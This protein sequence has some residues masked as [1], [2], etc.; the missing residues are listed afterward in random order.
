MTNFST[1]TILPTVRNREA[2]YNLFVLTI[3][4]TTA[5]NMQI[6]STFLLAVNAVT[7][8]AILAQK[9]LVSTSAIKDIPR[10]GFG[11]WN[12]KSDHHNASNAVEHAIKTGYRHIDCAAIYGNEPDVGRGIKKGLEAAGLKREEIWVTSKLWNDHHDALQVQAG[13]AKT[14]E[15]LGVGYLDL[16]LMHWPVASKDGKNSIKFVETWKA[17]ELLVNAGLVRHI[18]ISNFDPAQLEELLAEAYIRPYAHQMELHPYLPQSAWLQYHYEQGI[19][20]TAYS[21]LGNSNPTYHESLSSD[22]VRDMEKSKSTV[23]ALLEHP[24]VKDVAE[25]RNCTP[26]TVALKW[27][28][29]RGS[30]VIPKSQH[31]SR[32]EDNF[33]PCELRYE[34]IVALQMIG[35]RNLT[36]FNNPS[37]GWKVPLYKGLEDA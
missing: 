35:R 28:M 31:K 7:A 18:G 37:K 13:L 19:H 10:L 4:T 36:R 9:P 20:V 14:L 23:P 33:K 5:F 22:S 1:I 6:T 17:M 25:K 2:R 27:G 12:L 15:D 26:A 21:P 8:T 24:T 3:F 11:T 30:S 32:I 34:D 16:Y 29:S